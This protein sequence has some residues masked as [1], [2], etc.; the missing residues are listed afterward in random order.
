MHPGRLAEGFRRGR[1]ADPVGVQEMERQPVGGFTLRTE[2]LGRIV[3]TLVDVGLLV[4]QPGDREDDFAAVY[5]FREAFTD[6]Y[7]W[8]GVRRA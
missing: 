5:D 8:Q 6:T 1:A 3:F 2:D 4:T 7:A